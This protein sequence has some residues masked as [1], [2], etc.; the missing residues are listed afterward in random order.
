[1]RKVVEQEL[2]SG[3]ISNWAGTVIRQGQRPSRNGDQDGIVIRYELGSGRN[4]DQA[5]IVSKNKD[6]VE[7]E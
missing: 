6:H 3:R 7:I 1:L 5:G 2:C 4:F